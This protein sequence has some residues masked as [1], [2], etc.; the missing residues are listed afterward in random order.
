MEANSTCDLIIT[1]LS[2][3]EA[4]FH[5]I[6]KC[7]ISKL[8]LYSE[9]VCGR[10]QYHQGRKGHKE[11]V[12]CFTVDIRVTRIKYLSQIGQFILQI[13]ADF[14]INSFVVFAYRNAKMVLSK[15]QC[16]P[17]ITNFKAIMHS[18][19]FLVSTHSAFIPRCL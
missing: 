9:T 19:R 1:S 18:I 6:C 12:T 15:K 3:S 13:A 5:L 7:L 14:I 17:Y 8:L 4:T 2:L 10:I 11:T 16:G